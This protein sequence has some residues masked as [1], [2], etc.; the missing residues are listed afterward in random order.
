MDGAVTGESASQPK[1]HITKALSCKES[2]LVQ[3]LQAVIIQYMG[4]VSEVQ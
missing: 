2:V 4:E 3:P 1:K